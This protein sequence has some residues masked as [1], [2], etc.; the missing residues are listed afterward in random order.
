MFSNVYPRFNLDYQGEVVSDCRNNSSSISSTK[1]TAEEP[2]C[3]RT[4]VPIE[5]ILENDFKLI[6]NILIKDF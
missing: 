1:V 4:K 3:L 2:T 5:N 6:D